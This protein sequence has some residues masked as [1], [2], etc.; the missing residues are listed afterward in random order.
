M[1]GSARFTASQRFEAGQRYAQIFAASESQGRDSTPLGLGRRAAMEKLR[2]IDAAI[3]RKV[4]GD[5]R[6]TVTARLRE[7]LEP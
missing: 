7:A 3:L 1:G 4:C 5:Y 2:A 6:D